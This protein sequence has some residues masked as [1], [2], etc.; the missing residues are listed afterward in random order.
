MFD[1]LLNSKFYN[2][3]YRNP[4]CRFGL[5]RGWDLQARLFSNPAACFFFLSFWTAELE[6]DCFELPSPA[7]CSAFLFAREKRRANV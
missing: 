4:P 2:K 1:S 3:W 6:I 7:I 5:S